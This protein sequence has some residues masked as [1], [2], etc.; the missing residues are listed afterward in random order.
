VLRASFCFR[1]NKSQREAG[2]KLLNQKGTTQIV[3]PQGVE[4][5]LCLKLLPFAVGKNN[6]G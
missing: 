2:K 5:E 1:K 4:L 6:R 3:P